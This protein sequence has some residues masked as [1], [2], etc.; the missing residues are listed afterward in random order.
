[1]QTG[2]KEAD[3]VKGPWVVLRGGWYNLSSSLLPIGNKSA[4]IPFMR[5]TVVAGLKAGSKSQCWTIFN[6][7]AIDDG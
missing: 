2:S 4:A 5:E 7:L 6:L 3:M 1:M